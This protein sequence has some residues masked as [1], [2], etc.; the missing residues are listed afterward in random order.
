METIDHKAGTAM[1]LRIFC[2]PRACR[3]P[4]IAGLL[5]LVVLPL[6]SAIA[7][8]PSPHQLFDAVLMDAVQDGG[9]NYPAIASNPDFAVYIDYLATADRKALNTSEDELAFWI[10]AYNALAIQGIL[11]GKSPS[12]FFG[13]IGFFKNAEFTVGGE[14]MNLYDLERDIIIPLGE[15]RIHF[16]IV[17]ASHSCPKLRS[18]AYTA[19]RLDEQLEANTRHFINDSAR[20]RFDPEQKVAELSK[21]FDWFSED[22]I[23]PAGSVLNYVANYV[24][25]PKLAA[26]LRAGDYKLKFMKYNWSLN[27][28]PPID[29]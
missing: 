14:Q 20:N 1:K 9:V 11:D 23:K 18:E 2:S 24:D 13:R 3:R 10:N 7:Q 28:T 22:F 6:Q 12:T 8:Q 4:L 26:D 16:A 29:S 27:G 17:C 5:W 25:D 21:I 15:P 19:D